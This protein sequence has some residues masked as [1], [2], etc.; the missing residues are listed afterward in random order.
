MPGI[1][2]R[3]LLADDHPMLLDGLRKLLDPDFEVVAAVM[4]GR[5]LLASAQKLRPDLVIADIS[6]PLVDGLEAT[7][8]LRTSVPGARVL[9][10]SVHADPSWVREAF[11]AGACGYLN[12]ASAPEE[13]GTAVRE[14]LKGLFY[15]SPI[16]T[17]GVV[18]AAK[19][20]AAQCPETAL[21]R[22][23][24]S[25]VPPG[26]RELLTPR[27]LDT[28]RLVGRGLSNKEIARQLG[29]SV[30]TVRTHLNK[31]YDKLGSASRVELA[32]LTAPRAGVAM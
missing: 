17:R 14:V 19:G 1:R 24:G 9:I 20:L 22:T 29:V 15:I 28:V 26:V 23:A 30:A 12:K 6:M 18:D 4:D 5:E 21:P 13:I 31:A 27:E 8:Q 16:V 2:P 32:L 7:R 10:L 11:E 3:V 25:P